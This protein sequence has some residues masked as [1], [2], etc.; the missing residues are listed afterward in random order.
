MTP[1]VRAALTAVHAGALAAVLAGCG[2][3]R[4]FP[5]DRET[6]WRAAVGETVVWRPDSI[7]EQTRTVHA[8]RVDLAGNRIDYDLKVFTDPNLFARRPSTAVRVYVRQTKPRRVRFPRVEREFLDRI[9]RKLQA[10][11]A[12]SSP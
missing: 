2:S 3:T 7:D 9:G 5:Y 8:A 10:M 12:A 1:L 6:V 4:S 11:L